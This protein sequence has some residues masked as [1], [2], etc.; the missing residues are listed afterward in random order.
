MSIWNTLNTTVTYTYAFR[1]F[2]AWWM[3]TTVNILFSRGGIWQKLWGYNSF[4]PLFLFFCIK[5]HFYKFS[6]I[7]GWA[8]GLHS[9]IL[10][11]T[12]TR[13]GSLLL[14]ECSELSI[15]RFLEEES[16][17]KYEDIFPLYHCSCSFSST[18]ITP[19][20]HHTCKIWRS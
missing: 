13:F 12:H 7:S 4:I 16:D 14:D 2:A 19:A 15:A 3:F 11:L 17:R 6:I 8:F 9:T 10:S 20:P 1:Y 5:F 18:V